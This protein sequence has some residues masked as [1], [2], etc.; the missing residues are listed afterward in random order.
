MKDLVADRLAQT[1]EPTLPT[2]QAFN[3]TDFDDILDCGATN[4]Q[5]E[6]TKPF[7]AALP[8]PGGN[9]VSSRSKPQQVHSTLHNLNDQNTL[10]QLND[11]FSSDMRIL[12]NK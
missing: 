11:G 12:F 7:Q 2:T 1:K 3:K 10:F 6:N 9:K 5:I 8:P 4:I